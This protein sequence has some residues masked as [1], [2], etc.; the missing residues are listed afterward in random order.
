LQ[1]FKPPHVA[2][3]VGDIPE[4][5]EHRKNGLLIEP[6]DSKSLAAAILEFISDAKLQVAASLTGTER[7]D[8]FLPPMTRVY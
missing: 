1:K 7:Q 5:I 4:I 2:T 3:I 6:G 8:R